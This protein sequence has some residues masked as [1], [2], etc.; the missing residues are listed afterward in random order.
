MDP[1]LFCGKNEIHDP[2]CDF[3]CST[4]VQVLLEADQEDLKRAYAKAIEK[5][6]PGKVKA[7]ETFLIPEEPDGKRPTREFT[8]HLNRKRITRPVRYQKEPVR[9][10]AIHATTSLL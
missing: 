7:I 9:Y 6:Y 5:G 8:R 3:I 2:S 4:C 10:F 1:C